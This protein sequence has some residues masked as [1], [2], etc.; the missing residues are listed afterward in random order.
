MSTLLRPA[1]L[2]A[3]EFDVRRSY[4]REPFTFSHTLSGLDL[5]QLDSIMKLAERHHPYDYF[6]AGSAA[7]PDT[8]FYE[9]PHKRCHPGTA[10]DNIYSGAYRVILK[11]PEKYDSRYCD[12]RDALFVQIQALRGWPDHER[13]VRLDSAIVVTSA[14]A[15]TPL[16]FDPEVLFFFQI[17]GTKDYHLFSPATVS[18]PELERLYVRDVVDIGQVSFDPRAHAHEYVFRLRPGSGVHQPQN[19]PHW[20]ATQEAVSISYAISIETEASRALG[21]TR[22]FNYMQRRLGLHPG[23]PG[24][25]RKVD[26]LKAEAM[27]AALSLRRA[28]ERTA[29]E[30]EA[31]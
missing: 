17:A 10:L 28:L 24:R 14:G 3:N 1:R 23:P 7:A 2:I 11:R 6:V 13:F 16:H 25:K 18:E 12:L 22:G 8:P 31:R 19:A 29:G 20:I 9:V 5:F 27:R 26:A 4:D 30:R 15:I 21:R